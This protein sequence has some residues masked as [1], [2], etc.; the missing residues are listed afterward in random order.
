MGAETMDLP[1]D[2]KMKFEQ[3]DGG[4]SF[5]FVLSS[6]NNYVLTIF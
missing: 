2:E 5:G 1:M 3:G 6:S 4:R